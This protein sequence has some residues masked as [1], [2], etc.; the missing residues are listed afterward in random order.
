MR[1]LQCGGILSK[2]FERETM[3]RD[4]QK[5]YES[6]WS[7]VAKFKEDCVLRLIQDFNGADNRGDLLIELVDCGLAWTIPGEFAALIDS[8]TAP[9]RPSRATDSRCRADPHPRRTCWLEGFV[10][11][12]IC[13][14]VLV[15]WS[16]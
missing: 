9:S 6:R 3:L 1:K 11:E 15:R 12:S 13:P 14:K 5:L 2:N 16:L 4:L 10:V 8:G 7:L